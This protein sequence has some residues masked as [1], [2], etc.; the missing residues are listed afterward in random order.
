[1]TFTTF[2]MRRIEEHRF[3]V[4]TIGRFIAA[5]SV[6][7]VTNIGLLFLFTEYVGLYYLVSACISFVIA[8]GVGFVLQ[9]FWTFRERSIE[10][11]HAQAAGYFT[12]ST[13]NFFLNT[14]LLYFLVEKMHIWYI[15]AQVIASG[16]IAV[17][18]FLLYRYVIFLKK[19]NA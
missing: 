3:L 1:M 18:S 11:V 14:A 13:I 19:S 15:L 2:L 16:L 6:G 8:C 5:G 17:S 12:I 4:Y 7:A 9:K 10:S